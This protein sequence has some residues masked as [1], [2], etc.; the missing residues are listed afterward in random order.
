MGC[1]R[2]SG[3][4]REALN[5]PTEPAISVI[6]HRDVLV[7]SDAISAD[8]DH[9]TRSA[10]RFSNL[11]KALQSGEASLQYSQL[12]RTRSQWCRFSGEG[13]ADQLGDSEKT[14]RPQP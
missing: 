5:D 1:S 13:C 10:M 3:S 4:L 12:A 11:I 7:L 9:G 6:V 14:C 2:D 8:Y